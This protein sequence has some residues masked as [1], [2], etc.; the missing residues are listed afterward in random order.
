MKNSKIRILS[1]KIISYISAGEVIERPASVVKEL[2]ENSIDAQANRIIL[3]INNG[4]KDKII[5]SDNGCGI[6]KEDLPFAIKKYA[7]SKIYSL[8]DL[9]NISSMGF[10]GEALSSMSSVSN[11]EI[12]S[13]TSQCKHAWS[14]SNCMY[15]YLI[16]KAYLVGTTVS[17]KN[18]FYN[19]PARRKF[20]KSSYVEY[21]HIYKEIKKILLYHFNISL[22]V[23]HNQNKLQHFSKAYNLSQQKKRISQFFGDAF[24]G[25]AITIEKSTTEL[26]LRGWISTPQKHELKTEIKYF[27]V[28]GRSIKNKL[29][30]TAISSAYKKITR[31]Q[32]EPSFILYLLIQPSK[33]DVNIHPKKNNILFYEEKIVYDFIFDAISYILSKENVNIENKIKKTIIDNITESFRRNSSIDIYK[34]GNRQL[35]LRKKIWMMMSTKKRAKLAIQYLERKKQEFFLGKAIGIL[36]NTYILSNDDKKLI[37]VNIKEAHKRILCEKINILWKN[38]KI[39]SKDLT[40]P[41]TL[42]LTYLDIEIFNLYKNI[43]IK[44]GFEVCIFGETTIIIR[45]IPQYIVT[46]NVCELFKLIIKEFRYFEKSNSD[47][48]KLD[49]II[50]ILSQ[51]QADTLKIISN[52]KQMDKL[53][54]IVE[55]FDTERDQNPIWGSITINELDSCLKKENRK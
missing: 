45:K 46:K 16:P 52:Y 36:T 38:R 17:L 29:V 8:Q 27:Y 28:N 54:R 2:L 18:L 55:K 4:G 47:R 50:S 34:I 49:F 53:L 32:H 13:R 21:M 33:I 7:T 23:I 3:N 43:F 5:I 44:I 15:K 24:I 42:D 25:K 30:T 20:L 26:K 10:R 31:N 51:Y 48:Q 35:S 22:T 6:T 19:I 14:V 11:I 12:I 1:P 39:I 41:L 37:I 9:K 40:L